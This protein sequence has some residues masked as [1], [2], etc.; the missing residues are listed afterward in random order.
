MPATKLRSSSMSLHGVF[1]KSR[2]FDPTSLY[3]ANLFNLVFVF[4]RKNGNF[5]LDITDNLVFLQV[6]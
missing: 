2:V 6:I 4:L 3:E 1:H 5:F